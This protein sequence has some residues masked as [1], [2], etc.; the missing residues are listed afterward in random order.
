MSA[1]AEKAGAVTTTPSGRILPSVTVRPRPR[2]PCALPQRGRLRIPVS[3]DT[4]KAATARAAIEAGAD[5]IN[6][7][8]GL[9]FEPELAEVAA[10]LGVP[11]V[12]MH[13][14]GRPE[15]MQKLPP[16]PDIWAEV[17]LSLARSIDEAER[18]GVR[19][20]RLIID[21]GVGFGKTLEDNYALINNLPRL[22]HFNLPLLVGPSRKSFLGRTVNR[23]T[24]ELLPATAAAVAAC[25][26][27]GAHIVRVHD[28]WAM[29]DVCD[30]ADATV[31]GGW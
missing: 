20:E 19:R 15:V 5:I 27:R 9:K 31:R 30:I 7:I 23:P 26:L 10:D 12:L 21:P 4:Y 14:R 8:S 2:S 6:D 24:T 25:V 28:V 22:G 29:R 18:R 17:E 13:T 3:I 11:L 1:S 16:S